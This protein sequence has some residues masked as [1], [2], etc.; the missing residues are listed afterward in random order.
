MGSRQVRNSPFLPDVNGVVDVG[1]RSCQWIVVSARQNSQAR[2]KA[3]S[4]AGLPAPRWQARWITFGEMA[5]LQAPAHQTHDV[6][7]RG[8]AFR[9]RLEAPTWDRYPTRAT[10]SRSRSRSRA[11]GRG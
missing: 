10:R 2:L 7:V 9:V 4:P 6:P 11:R 8:R 3:G 1:A 5:N